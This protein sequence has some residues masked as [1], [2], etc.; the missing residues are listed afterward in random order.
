MFCFRQDF[1]FSSSKLSISIHILSIA[2][3]I[4]SDCGT[5]HLKVNLGRTHLVSTTH[6]NT[7][8]SFSFPGKSTVIYHT[9]ILLE[10][11]LRFH[12]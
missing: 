8:Y 11:H 9:N 6:E 4:E 7:F 2:A 12:I 10:S 1:R 5:F 3:N